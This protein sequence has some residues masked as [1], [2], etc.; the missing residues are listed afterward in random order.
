VAFFFN[1]VCSNSVCMTLPR[2]RCGVEILQWF[3]DRGHF[4]VVHLILCVDPTLPWIG[5]GNRLLFL[6]APF[7][8]LCWCVG[9]YLLQGCQP[10]L[11][12]SLGGFL[13]SFGR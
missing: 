2:P 8:P 11:V 3:V 5:V 12:V 6:G 10:W 9:A 7:S 1:V 4:R 13:S